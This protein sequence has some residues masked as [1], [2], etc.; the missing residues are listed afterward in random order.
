MQNARQS[1]VHYTELLK[2]ETLYSNYLTWLLL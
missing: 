1:D 2:L